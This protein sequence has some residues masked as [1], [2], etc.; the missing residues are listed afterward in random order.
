MEVVSKIW[1][2]IMTRQNREIIKS[3]LNGFFCRYSPK[4]GENFEMESLLKMLG[5]EK[6]RLMVYYVIIKNWKMLFSKL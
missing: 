1:G 4:L 3:L 5:I 2:G 6:E